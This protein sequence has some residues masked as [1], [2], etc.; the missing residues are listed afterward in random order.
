[1][2]WEVVPCPKAPLRK[3]KKGRVVQGLRVMAEKE[4]KEWSLRANNNNVRGLQTGKER[5][6][7]QRGWEKFP[8]IK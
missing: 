7:W 4:S 1:L 5:D 6:H 3:E 2:L 8:A